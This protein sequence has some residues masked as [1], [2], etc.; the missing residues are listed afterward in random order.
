MSE[1]KLG[2]T[3]KSAVESYLRAKREKGQLTDEEIA[4]LDAIGFKWEKRKKKT[5][6]EKVDLYVHCWE[7]GKRWRCNE[8]G[9]RFR[10]LDDAFRKYGKEGENL[11]TLRARVRRGHTWHGMTIARCQTE[12][13]ITSSEYGNLTN[14]LKRDLGEGKL[15][16]A[17]LEKLRHCDFPFES[18]K[19]AVR[20]DDRLRVIWDSEQ[21][22]APDSLELQINKEYAWKCPVC[23]YRWTRRLGKERDSKGCPACL[24]KV[25]IPG[26][27][28]LATCNPDIAEEWDYE[29]NG[30]LTPSDIV[31]GSA[32]R[33]WWKCQKCG[34]EWQAPPVKRKI[35][36]GSCP[37][38]AGRKLKKGVNDLASQYPEVALDYLPELNGGI[39]ADEVIIKYGTKVIWKCHVCGHEWKNDVYNRTRAPKPS[40]CVKCQRR[41]SIPRYRQ[42]AIERLG[43]LAETNPNLAAAWDYEKNGNLTPSDITANSNGTY[44]FLCRS[45]GAPTRAIR[46]Q[47]SRCAWAV[48]ARPEE[49]KTVRRWFVSKRERYMK[50][51]EMLECKLGNI[52]PRYPT[53]ISDRRTCAG[54]HWKYLDE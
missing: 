12:R 4:R 21:N 43:A 23:G 40:G 51:S 16:E 47:R 46:E 24:G 10:S 50:P 26:W 32:K 35:G 22:G 53:P 42:M 6:E 25:V 49:E 13:P 7:S 11:G 17:Q 8:T 27:T 20:L 37:Y 41:A 18:I 48:C 2:Q 31:S 5:I 30:N 34:G 33:V 9:E 3:K 45:C 38:C 28:D 29:R 52:H 36:K 1:P 39:P 15:T 54:Y 14:S 19:E 44:W